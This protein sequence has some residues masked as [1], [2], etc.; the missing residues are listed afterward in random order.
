MK[1]IDLKMEEVRKKVIEDK[2]G[3]IS[4][5]AWSVAQC[6]GYIYHDEEDE[7]E[8]ER[9]LKAN[10]ILRLMNTEEIKEAC[11]KFIESAKVLERTLSFKNIDDEMYRQETFEYDS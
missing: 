8:A 7:R 1:D 5:A 11:V 3:S 4:R 9:I 2:T 6:I 10:A